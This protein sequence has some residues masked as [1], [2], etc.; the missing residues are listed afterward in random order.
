MW[1]PDGRR[2]TWRTG[3]VDRDLAEAAA[4]AR[5]RSMAPPVISE[6]T[7]STLAPALTPPASVTLKRGETG[8]SSEPPELAAPPSF[9]AKFD[10]WFF[11]DLARVLS[12]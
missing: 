12:R 5:L 11:S 3:E 2:S 4:W 7:A 1:L 9:V 10:A 6:S 8:A